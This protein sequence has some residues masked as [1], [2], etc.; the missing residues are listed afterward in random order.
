[1]HSSTGVPTI[2]DEISFMNRKTFLFYY[3]YYLKE[4]GTHK[5]KG[6]KN[7]RIIKVSKIELD[8]LVKE[9]FLRVQF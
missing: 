6:A 2:N 7:E 9:K 3:Y 8:K 1:M 5:G 4:P